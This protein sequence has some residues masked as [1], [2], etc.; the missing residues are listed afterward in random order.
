MF[1]ELFNI[2]LKE[3]IQIRRD[4]RM[5]PLILIAPIL[6]L[7]IYGY[8]A[9][10]DI[11]NIPT[12]VYDSD[13]SAESREYL[14]RFFNSGYF[15]PKL[16]AES[17]EEVRAAL[18]SGSAKAAIVVPGGFSRD[19]RRNRGAK[20]QFLIDG[21]NSN[22]A[23]LAAN[24]A[25]RISQR[26]AIEKLLARLRIVGAGEMLDAAERSAEG[27]MLVDN[28]LRVWYNPSLLSRNFMVPGVIA[29]ILL[30]MTSIMTAMSMV[31]EKELG[32]MEQL[33]VT[34]LR[35]A[36]LIIGK[37]VPFIG[38]GMIDVAIVLLAAVFWFGIPVRGSIGLL[39]ALSLLFLFS[40]LGLGLLISTFCRTQQQAMI[41]AFFTIMPM[42]LLS[43]FI[44]PIANM[45]A[46]I[47]HLTYLMPMRYFLII[48]RGIILKGIGVDMLAA[49]IYPLA[50]F[51][52]AMV[53]LCMV[54]FRKRIE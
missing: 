33:I 38:I 25:A 9:T 24:Y 53:L 15:R 37:L 47:Q 42:M 34:P 31:R 27:E 51:G 20:A 41:T 54:R 45:P 44:F 50:V 48:I 39:F 35:P 4:K 6:Q 13:H 16:Y 7:L 17:Y 26:Y 46:A 30:V 11:E 43:G 22:E 5:F 52:I 12:A 8:A 2:V 28:R 1:R 14:R 32:T 29:L 19:I 23:T 18:D 36:A 49:Q 21:T 10:F 40:T 3:L